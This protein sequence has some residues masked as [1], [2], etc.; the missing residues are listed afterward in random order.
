MTFLEGVFRFSECWWLRLDK[1]SRFAAA[2]L[3]GDDLYRFYT[4][5]F[6]KLAVLYLA[7]STRNLIFMNDVTNH[8][9]LLRRLSVV[10]AIGFCLASVTWAQEAI[11]PTYKIVEPDMLKG[12]N[13]YLLEKERTG[14][15]ARMEKETIA[16]A[17]N[18]LENPTP[19][20]GL[21]KTERNFTFFYDPSFVVPKSIRDHTGQ[22]VAEAGSRVNP[23]DYASMSKH[24]LFFDG[25][26]RAQVSKAEDLLKHYNG[27]I[28][29]ILT[30][31]PVG[32]ISRQWNQQVYFDQGGSLV[33]KLGIRHVPSL[34]SQDGKRLRIDELLVENKR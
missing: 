33:R 6:D 19:V 8:L 34:V 3:L 12:I 31:G 17:K 16:R 11:G 14:D 25:S 1:E 32:E 26:D 27:L 29:P 30:N 13:A 5:C 2:L 24:M 4:P 23:L 9:V 18:K 10:S 22:V 28:K 21:T 7:S 15:L 20:A